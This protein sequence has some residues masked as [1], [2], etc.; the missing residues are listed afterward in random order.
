MIG[1]FSMMHDIGKIHIP[2]SI[3]KKEG[4]LNPEQWEIMKSHCTA[5][6]KILGKKHFYRLAREIARSHHER[7][8]GS[9]YPDGL[10][11][12]SIPL[13]ARVVTVADVFDALTH[14]RPYK[15][16]W[17]EERAMDEM[18][19]LSGKV[20]DPAIM[21]IFLRAQSEKRVCVD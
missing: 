8:D 14:V 6:E 18:K 16:A 2:D 3:L 11:G 9:G 21:G 20:F 12:D 5:G 17:P 10:K 15:Q 19:R 1:F 4:P 13:S 7:W